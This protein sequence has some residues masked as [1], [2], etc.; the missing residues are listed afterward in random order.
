MNIRSKVL[1][2]ESLVQPIVRAKSAKEATTDGLGGIAV[3]RE[4]GRRSSSRTSDRHRLVGEAVRFTH[5]GHEHQG[6][7]INLSGGGAMIAGP[8]QGLRLWDRIDL[9]LGDHGTIES[10]VRWIRAN[11]VGLEFAH[12]TQLHCSDDQRASVLRAAISR[13]FPNMKFEGAAREAP[14]SKEEAHVDEHR[15]ARRHALIWSAMLHHDYQSTKV[16][17]R[18]ISASGAMLEYTGSARVGAEPLLEF[19]GGASIS[20]TIAWAGGDHLGLRFHSNL[21]LEVLA[22]S[23]PEVTPTEWVP[24]AYLDKAKALG[25]PWDPRWNRL[26]IEQLQQEL[27]GYLKY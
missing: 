6:E 4:E 7:L 24:P 5:Q 8:P 14:S 2:T 1:G 20:G 12:E 18:N 27:A 15:C 13:S 16:R 17:I 26:S 25:S 3:R 22:K 11:R 23:V 9:H 21:D 19:D 10:A